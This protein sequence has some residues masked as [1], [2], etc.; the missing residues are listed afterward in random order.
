[1]AVGACGTGKTTFIRTLLEINSGAAGERADVDKPFTPY[2]LV[3]SGSSVNRK[4]CV[5]DTQGFGE[6]CNYKEAF[7][8]ISSFIQEHLEKYL[9][10][11]TKINRDPEFEDTRVHAVLYFIS[12]T[13]KGLKDCDIQLMKMLHDKTNLIPVLPKA[14]CYSVDGK[15]KIKEKVR[16]A[17]EEHKIE[18]FEFYDGA[19]GEGVLE[20]LSIIG[21]TA[22]HTAGGKQV[23]GRKYSYGIAEVDNPAHCE[24]VHLKKML[25]EGAWRDLLDSTS[26]YFYENYR[27]KVLKSVGD[28]SAAASLPNR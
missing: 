26:N 27:K 7:E 19:E 20:P 8:C 25:L 16:K 2:T 17:L 23:R 5:I 4:L 11:E 15:T 21:S 18:T 10:E 13:S 3:D 22:E 28:D 12:P 6:R 1:M 24:F 9:M 14:D